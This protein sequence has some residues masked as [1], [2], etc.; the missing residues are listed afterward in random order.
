MHVY[1]AGIG[2][3]G[4]GPLAEMAHQLGYCVSGSDLEDSAGLQK[5]RR[6]RP[7]PTINVGQTAEQIAASHSKNPIDWYVYSSALAWA[8][9]P[10]PELAWVKKQGLRHSKRDEFISHL[11]EAKGLDMLAIAGSH[12]KTTTA[13]MIIWTLDQLGEK[14]SYSLGGK[15]AGLPAARLSPTSRWFVYEADEFDRNF[16][17]FRPKLSLISGIDYDHPEVYDTRAEFVDAFRQFVGQSDRV[18]IG[19]HDFQVLEAG[20]WSPASPDKFQVVVTDPADSR[21]S[22]AGAVNRQNASLV[23]AGAKLLGFDE[24]KLVDRLNHFPGSWRRFEAIAPGVYTD[25]AHSPVKIAG[26]LQR[27]QEIGKPVVVVYEPHSNQ[28][29]HRLGQHYRDLFVGVKRVFWLPTFLTR[30]DPDLKVLAPEDLIAKLSNPG[31]ARPAAMDEQLLAAIKEELASGSIVVGMSAS[32]LD[33]W[34]RDNLADEN[35]RQF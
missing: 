9:P 25:Y 28:R 31:V 20:G 23:L 15:L 34:L 13:A 21:I 26:C 1:L 29:Q 17:A 19:R 10:N 14:I 16:L 22:L 30:E 5:M 2:G 32:G 4:I 11:L 6:W 35:Y 3:S 27:A 18:V 24:D 12:G 7:A 8:N 33:G